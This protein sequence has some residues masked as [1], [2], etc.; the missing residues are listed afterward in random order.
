MTLVSKKKW[1]NRT[2]ERGVVIDKARGYVYVRFSHAGV[3]RKELI[4]LV[5][6]PEAIDKANFRAQQIR[7]DRRAQ[8]PGFDARKKRLLLEDAADMFLR[9]HGEK[10]Q[11]RRGQAVRPLYEA[12]KQAWTGR[13]VDTLAADDVRDY[14]EQRRKQGVSESTI[15]ASTRLG[16]D[17]Q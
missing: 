3:I 6:E 9:L 5:D 10:R 13:Y 17:V 12:F 2:L 7:Q 1:R 15:T 14:R 16:H 11:S 8:V 4:G